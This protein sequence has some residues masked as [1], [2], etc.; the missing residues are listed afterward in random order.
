MSTSSRV[1][2]LSLAALVVAGSSGLAAQA[3]PASSPLTWSTDRTT[4]TL[5]VDGGVQFDWAV[6]AWWNLGDTF[7]PAE[8]FGGDRVWGELFVTPALRVERRATDRVTL[9]AKA[10]LVGAGTL[11]LD[12]FDEG[13]TGRVTLDEAHGGI[14]IAIRDG[15]ALDVSAGP[16]RYVIGSGFLAAVGASNGFE[17]GA[18]TMFPRKAWQNAVVGA[19]TAGRVFADAFYLD[20]N[21]LPDSDSDTT[22]AGFRAEFRPAPTEYVGATYMHVLSSTYPYVQAPVTIVPDGRDGLRVVHAY[23]R[24]SP[25]RTRVPGLVTLF[26]VAREWNPHVDMRAW[27]V[28]GEVMRTFVGRRWMPTVGY[29]FRYY[30]GDNPDT[31]SL[32]R[33]DPLF[34][35]GYPQTFASGS[36]GSLAFYNANV[37]MHRFRASAVFTPRDIVEAFYSHLR[38]PQVNSP[39]QFGQGARLV[40]A[41]GVP[42]LAVGVPHPHLSDDLYVQYTRVISPKVFLTA[43]IA[44]SHPGRGLRGLSADAS[45]PW[46][47]GIVNATIGY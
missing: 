19:V 11:G 12:V 41:D 30:S 5:T 14:R 33:F 37:L 45:D 18:V 25:A 17:R 1:R 24:V 43:G 6:N 23:G 40:E 35:E 22:L 10:S 7:A 3:P 36:N 46:L 32:E 42:V 13:N 2:T 4:A 34:Y 8:D 21:E 26:D 16:R 15:L 39:L 31:P 28:N 29:A 9:Y 47:G 38:A 20:P 44:Y 27:A